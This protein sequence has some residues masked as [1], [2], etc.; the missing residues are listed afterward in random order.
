MTTGERIR[1]L[2]L[3]RGLTLRQLASAIDVSEATMAR[4]EQ[5]TIQTLTDQRADAIAEALGVTRAA[6][7][8]ITAD[9]PFSP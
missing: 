5:G 3:Q 6:L 1:A 9:E 2:R 7:H 4:Y 8:G